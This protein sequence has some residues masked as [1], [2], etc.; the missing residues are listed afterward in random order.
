MKEIEKPAAL[1]ELL[2]DM[3]VSGNY[4]EEKH[5]D[6][7]ILL[8]FDNVDKMPT[9]VLVTFQIRLTQM[10]REHKSLRV[11]LTA[12]HNPHLESFQVISDKNYSQKKQRMRQLI[13]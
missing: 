5:S 6:G 8:I 12:T 4:G 7:G 3:M 10:L 1:K 9:N 11:L 2:K 13:M